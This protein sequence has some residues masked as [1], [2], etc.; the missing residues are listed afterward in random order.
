MK[1]TIVTQTAKYEIYE[2]V[3]EVYAEP[4]D[5]VRMQ[6][7]NDEIAGTYYIITEKTA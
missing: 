5:G 2:D 1:V 4:E 6:Q 7:V 3:V